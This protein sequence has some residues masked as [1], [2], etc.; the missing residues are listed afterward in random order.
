MVPEDEAEADEV[1][2]NMNVEP[3]AEMKPDIELGP[4]EVG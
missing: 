1:D 4:E 3:E 2:A